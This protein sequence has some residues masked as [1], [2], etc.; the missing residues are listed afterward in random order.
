MEPLSGG[1]WIKYGPVHHTFMY[2]IVQLFIGW[3]GKD[4]ADYEVRFSLNTMV[5]VLDGVNDVTYKVAEPLTKLYEDK[6]YPDWL[7]EIIDEQLP[8]ATL[9]LRGE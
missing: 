2:D 9:M 3:E 4:T 6:K 5:V 7:Q 1:R 8:I